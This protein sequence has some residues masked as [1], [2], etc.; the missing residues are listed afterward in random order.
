MPQAEVSIGTATARQHNNYIQ[1]DHY[2]SW[3]CTHIVGLPS[4]SPLA[5]ATLFITELSY[6]LRFLVI[7]TKK[8]SELILNDILVRPL[9]LPGRFR[10]AASLSTGN[11]LTASPCQIIR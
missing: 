5:A 8:K 10:T 2:F 6:K 3:M 4:L 7:T 1:W 9:S 11:R